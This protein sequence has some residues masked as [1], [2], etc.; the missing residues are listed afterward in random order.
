M[1]NRHQCIRIISLL[2][3]AGAG[4]ACISP[5][6]ADRLLTRAE[7]SGFSETTRYEEI[8][9][10]LALL[11]THS[12]LIRVDTF[13]TTAEG[14]PLPLAVLGSPPPQN[15]DRVD[16]NNRILIF[17]N[18]NIHA[19][20]VAGKEAC[21]MLLREI[22]LGSLQSLLDHTVLLV[23]PIYNAD[24]NERIDPRHRYWQKGPDRGVGIRP[25]AQS[26]DLNRDMMKLESPEAQGLVKNVLAHWDPDLVVDCHTTNG[27]YHREP[28][29]YAPSHL[30][31]GDAGLLHFNQFVM[32]PWIVEKTTDQSGYTSIPYGNFQDP[33]KPELGW[34]TFDHRPRYVSN[35][36]SL[37]NQLSILIEMYAYA[38]YEVRVKACYAFLQ[39][40]LEYAH[41]EGTEIRAV[42]NRAVQNT[43]R[44]RDEKGD[45]LRFHTEFTAK[46]GGE[47]LIIQGY[48]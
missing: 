47:P 28:I 26:L 35:Y 40:I 23:A 17:I 14:R 27:S 3:L 13:G 46:A 33:M 9:E 34:G 25:N 10:F 21:L 32:L 19:G 12:D 4:A 2:L 41:L 20:E 16:R 44:G 39:S 11:E 15:P 5:L 36:V 18:A 30:P 43:M 1:K 37:R 8:V 22:C 24:G 7:S 29:T 38:D 42:R 6:P 31:F 48:R 45:P